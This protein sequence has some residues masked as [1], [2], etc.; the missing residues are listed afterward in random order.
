M[1]T[2]SN[3]ASIGDLLSDLARQA[4]T[5][6]RQEIDL[7]QTEMRQNAMRLQR[8]VTMMVAGGLIALLG[9]GGL[10]AMGIGLLAQ[11]LPTWE[12]SGIIGGAVALIGLIVLISGQVGLRRT[13]LA[14]TRTLRAMVAPTP[15][16]HA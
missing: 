15:E 1:P 5:L 4:S 16:A 6:I 14:P 7:A 11:V 9:L 2:D 8:N 13:Q 3:Q 12:A 10:V